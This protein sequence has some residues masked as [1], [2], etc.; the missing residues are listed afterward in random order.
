MAKTAVEPGTR[1]WPG[2]EKFNL[3]QDFLEKNKS[4]QAAQRRFARV[5]VSK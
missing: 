5:K 2:L 3:V 1:I 4:V